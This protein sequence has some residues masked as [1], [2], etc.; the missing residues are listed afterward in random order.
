MSAQAENRQSAAAFFDLDG[1]LFPL[2]TL[3]R[4][5]FRALQ[6]ERQIPLLNCA[7]W[8]GETLRHLPLG[9]TQAMQRNK[10]YLRG[11]AKEQQRPLLPPFFPEAVECACRHVRQGDK[12]V[13]V[14]GTLEF[15]A[16]RAAAALRSE[17]KIRGC[18][19]EIRVCA[20]RLEEIHGRWSGCVLGEAMFGEEKARAVRLLAKEWKLELPLCSAYGDSAQD[21]WLLA[22]V[23]RAF[24]VNPSRALR[25]VARLYGWPVLCWIPAVTSQGKKER[26]YSLGAP[27]TGTAEHFSSGDAT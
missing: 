25:R 8:V 14:T 6:W 20:T 26:D 12:I 7:R 21:R 19:A 4:R 27:A 22:S 11:I 1:T 5:F 10:T 24:A 16:V 2:P 23:G 9:L 18:D 3:E 13:L 17:L 15:L